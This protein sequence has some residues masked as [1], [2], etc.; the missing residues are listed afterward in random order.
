VQSHLDIPSPSPTGRHGRELPNQIETVGKIINSAKWRDFHTKFKQWDQ[1]SELDKNKIATAATLKSE[2]NMITQL[3]IAKCRWNL[4]HR[5][6]II[7]SSNNAKPVAP[8]HLE[9]NAITQSNTARFRR[10]LA[11]TLEK[12]ML[13]SEI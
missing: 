6:K 5:Q 8:R 10:N 9:V 3:N 11:N 4:L 13:S 2:V 12:K 1:R 7:L